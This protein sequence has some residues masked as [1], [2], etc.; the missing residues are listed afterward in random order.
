MSNSDSQKPEGRE[1]DERNPDQPEEQ[2]AAAK[3]ARNEDT[4][5]EALSE[6]LQVSFKF[7]KLALIALVAIYLLNGI[8]WV[9]QGQMKIKL[10]FGQPVGVG[11]RNQ[12]VLK[13]G[14][15]WHIRWPW[16][17]V[18]TIST[19]EKT[20]TVNSQF[21]HFE[22]PG[23]R[24]M[25]ERSSLSPRRDGYL[26]TADRGL[27]HMQVEARYEPRTD[28][29]GALDYAFRVNNPG[30]LLRGFVYESTIEVVGRNT[31]SEA[32]TEEKQRVLTAI[33]DEVRQRLRQ[34]QER[35]GF[36]AGVELTSLDYTSSPIVPT[37]VQQAYQ[38]AREAENRMNQMLAKAEEE[39][40]TILQEGRE[41]RASLLGEARAYKTR[42]MEL[43]KADAGTLRE[44]LKYYE[45]SPEMARIMRERH[46]ERM[47]QKVLGDSQD[48][49]VLHGSE[50]GSQ[51]E[52][53]VLL[54]R[55][56]KRREEEENGQQQEGQPEGQRQRRPS[57]M[58]RPA[59][60]SH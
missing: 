36:S 40:S 47:I 14:S 53:R 31:V 9:S 52:L 5:G 34:F 4:G 48:A 20:L 35:N 2:Q 49:F 33:R 39:R 23:G 19:D 32:V 29:Q 18:K 15:G 58:G 21:W 59:P 41:A 24:E 1:K 22:P 60:H 10:R 11:P 13:P 50:S 57:Q 7:L 43:A 17:Q 55:Q 38:R 25:P 16:E 42:V 8:F 44:L 26:L 54:G 51:R 3:Q 6:A 37:A 46:Y 27:M 45:Q 28:E 12:Y 30:D 56:Q